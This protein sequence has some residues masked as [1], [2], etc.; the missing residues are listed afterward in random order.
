MRGF[1]AKADVRRYD[2]KYTYTS[3]ATTFCRKIDR[4][5]YLMAPSTL[6]GSLLTDGCWWGYDKAKPYFSTKSGSVARVWA[7]FRKS[8]Y[9][10]GP[11][12]WEVHSKVRQKMHICKQNR[13]NICEYQKKIVLLHDFSKLISYESYQFI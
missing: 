5:I 8:S 3:E 10:E 1:K 13:M 9:E 12:K 6:I 2:K 11:T 7:A 4:F